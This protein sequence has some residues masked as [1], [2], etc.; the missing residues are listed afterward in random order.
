M[1]RRRILQHQADQIF[2]ADEERGR[3]KWPG[4][5][6]VYHRFFP[7]LLVGERHGLEMM[8]QI[9]VL[10]RV[11]RLQR[12]DLLDRRNSRFREIGGLVVGIMN[13]R[14]HGFRLGIEIGKDADHVVAEA[15]IGGNLRLG[16]QLAVAAELGHLDAEYASSRVSHN[17]DAGQP[18]DLF[19]TGIGGES[20][21][22]SHAGT[23]ASPQAAWPTSSSTSRT[24]PGAAAAYPSAPI[25]SAKACEIG[26]PPT[27][28]LKRE[29]RLAFSSS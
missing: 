15:A 27:M 12:R 6:S 23:P 19:A 24:A 17:G 16:D 29:R 11:S 8:R 9:A 7:Y 25:R 18:V 4:Q 13:P 2:G 20:F 21:H 26:P 1:H 28:T 22:G 3:G 10:I 5:R 14:A